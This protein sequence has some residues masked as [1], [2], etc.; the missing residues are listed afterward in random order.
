[1]VYC[2]DIVPTRAGVKEGPWFN[3]WALVCALCI[4]EGSY[5]LDG[6]WRNLMDVGTSQTEM[7]MG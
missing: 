3:S 6:W 5:E 4:S 7:L 2:V 1:M